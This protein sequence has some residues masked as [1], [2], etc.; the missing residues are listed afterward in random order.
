MLPI[1]YQTIAQQLYGNKIRVRVCGVC[2]E[3]KQILLVCHKPILGTND[4]WSPPGGGVDEGESA[5]DALKREFSEET[6][7]EIEVGKLL[8]TR[9]FIKAP[10]HA[11]EL[12]FSVKILGGK[13]IVGHDPEMSKSNQ[14]IKEVAWL[15]LQND[16]FSLKDFE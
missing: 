8:T 11:I 2:I 13:L 10:L 1:N 9:E 12:F 15:P 5:A 14:M 3:N 16:V 7:L 6:G 4:Y